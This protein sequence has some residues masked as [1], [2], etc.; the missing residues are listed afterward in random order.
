MV[1]IFNNLIVFLVIVWWPVSVGALYF[2]YACLPC[3]LN[4]HPRLQK[5]LQVCSLRGPRGPHKESDVAVYA[6]DKVFWGPH[7]PRIRG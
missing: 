2:E 3:Q 5:N 1:P 7:E 4:P 6:S